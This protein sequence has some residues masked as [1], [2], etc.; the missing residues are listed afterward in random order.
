MAEGILR[1]GLA[2]N[3]LLSPLR[4]PDVQMAL[5]FVLII[6][7]LLVPLPP[8][9]LD[10][11]FSLSIGSSLLILLMA[12]Y[13][14]EPLEFSTFP[15]ILLLTTM[16]R[17]GLNA[18][19]TRMILGHAETGVSRV[20]QGFGEVVVGGNYFV[21]FVMF[22]ILI[23]INFL[24]ITKGASRV[25]EVS[26]RFTLDAMPG[27]QMTI[28]AELQAGH[29]DR[30]EARRRRAKV[31]READFH[32]AMDGAGKF[33]RG[34][35][36]AGIVITLVNI[37]AGFIIGVTQKGMTF[38][39]AAK[40]YTLLTIGDGLVS[41]IP[42]LVVSLAAGIVVTRASGQIG[43]SDEI[44][45]ELTSHPKALFTAA[46][47]ISAIGLVPGMPLA[48]FL[49]LGVLLGLGGRIAR[50][51]II[52]KEE[53]E[54]SDVEK[55]K[56]EG[57]AERIEASMQVVTLALEV[58]VELVSLV[59]NAKD[60]EVLE[61]IVSA[62][63]QIAQDLGIIVPKV[64]I[65]DNIQLRPDEYQ[66]LLKGNVIG[67]GRLHARRLL[68]MGPEDI[69][70]PIDGIKAKE[71]AYGLDAVWVLQSQRDEAAFRG[72]TVVN[73]ATVIVTHIDKLIK[74]HAHEL[75]GRQEVHRLIENLK[76]ENDKV[77]DEVI[78]PDRLT[79]GDVVKVLQHL[80]LEQ[81]SV[82]DM[83]SIFETLADH[84]KGRKHPVEL[85]GHVR[86]A[87]GRGI[88]KKY[89]SPD[90][91]LVVATLDRA[92]EDALIAGLEINPDGSTSLN[93]D[94][95]FAK[96]LLD[97]IEVSMKQ[98]EATGTIPIIMCGPRIRW[99]LRKIV[100]RFVPGV[101]VIAFDEI[102]SDIPTQVVSMVTIQR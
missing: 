80:L 38:G 98:F 36:I 90:N 76:R 48:P 82:R 45:S 56:S 68:A 53:A 40:V 87:L 101:V 13:V 30:D 102:P 52:E 11:F 1:P 25:A 92:V 9:A 26:A 33:V 93:V 20:V 91:R 27:K 10:L 73:C 34:D 94:P 46:A 44:S 51:S 14:K 12:I 15:T 69:M 47:L 61:R 85:V 24:V 62:R 57:S 63:Q 4:S 97:G 71:P 84:A 77:V 78:A 64:L 96:R 60:G 95:E 8:W 50:R 89:L 23:V 39:D 79:L 7:A 88:M 6:G 17:L 75:I 67:K 72:Y 74:D 59:D 81:V 16:F 31:Q 5:L 3:S 42:A 43:L 41:Q 22:V 19:T 58:G 66:V 83:L 35:A 32:G 49:G 70:D 21:G 37:I 28:D 2:G 55:V 54:A 29:I 100:H 86:K 65:R 18:A 99:D